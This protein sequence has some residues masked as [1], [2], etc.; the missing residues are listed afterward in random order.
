MSRSCGKIALAD[1]GRQFVGG[2][3]EPPDEI[4]RVVA[5]WT[6]QLFVT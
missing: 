3:R 6:V 1:D 4:E 5:L 2:P